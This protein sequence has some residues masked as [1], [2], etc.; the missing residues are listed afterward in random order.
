MLSDAFR[1]EFNLFE[2]C[3]EESDL[4]SESEETGGQ[5][6]DMHEVDLTAMQLQRRVVRNVEGQVLTSYRDLSHPRP[7][8]QRQ[9]RL[10][11]LVV[12]ETELEAER[13]CSEFDHAGDTDQR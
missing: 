7:A 4:D 1:K 10:Q 12:V 2:T 3:E 8:R 6:S 13:N 11:H 5:Q 9:R